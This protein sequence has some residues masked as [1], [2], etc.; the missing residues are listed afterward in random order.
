[1]FQEAIETTFSSAVERA[2]GRRVIAFL[3]Q[4]NLDPNFAV[5]IFRL[6]PRA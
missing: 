5:E 2:T 3:S 6:A 1:M 4:T